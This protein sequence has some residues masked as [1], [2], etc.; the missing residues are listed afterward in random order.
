MRVDNSGNSLNNTQFFKTS[1]NSKTANEIENDRVWLNLTNDQGLFKQML[2]G[3]ITGATND[4]DSAFD[5]ESM[6]GNSF[7]DFYSINQNRNFT[8]Q[9]RA[10]PFDENDI[11]PLGFKTTISGVF[12]INRYQVDG[13]LTNQAIYIEDKVTNTIVDL[14]NG[15]YTFTT[16]AGTFNDR[17]V[18][19]YVNKTLGTDSISSKE[20]QVFVSNINK[21]IKINSAIETIDKVLVYDL[22]GKVIYKKNSINNTEFLI[23]NIE[24]T[25]Q[26]LLIKIILENG[27]TVARKI[28]F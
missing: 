27:T 9:G 22:L 5:G 26:T 12:K 2:I 4:F 25:K 7:I 28:I 23:S 17:F 20:N 6:N 15:D 21:Q 18:L 10:L 19:R 24:I 1:S 14:N 13:L 16:V 3:Y 11:V 8:I